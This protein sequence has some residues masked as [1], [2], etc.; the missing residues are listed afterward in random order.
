MVNAAD[1][2]DETT[3]HYLPVER[4]R[5]CFRRFSRHFERAISELQGNFEP[6]MA[7]EGFYQTKH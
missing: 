6:R 2:I 4:L 1:Q 7:A 5:K 3:N